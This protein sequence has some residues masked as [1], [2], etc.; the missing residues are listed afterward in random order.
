M[1]WKAV[2]GGLMSVLPALTYTLKVGWPSGGWA[3]IAVMTLRAL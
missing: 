3:C 2:G 1:L